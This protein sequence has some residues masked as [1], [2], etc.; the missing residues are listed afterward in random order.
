MV[1]IGDP[2]KGNS[3]CLREQAKTTKGYLNQLQHLFPL[4]P[5]VKTSK[6]DRRVA[7]CRHYLT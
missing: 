2:T 6:N 3:E 4:R 5:S 1:L 7:L